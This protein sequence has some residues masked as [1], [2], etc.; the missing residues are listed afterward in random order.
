M[1]HEMQNT[2]GTQH[3]IIGWATIVKVGEAKNMSFI[4]IKMRYETCNQHA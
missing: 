4:E 2:N 1:E 3:R